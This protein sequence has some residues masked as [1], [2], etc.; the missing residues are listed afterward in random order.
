MKNG[1]IITIE[2]CHAI[3]KNFRAPAGRLTASGEQVY[4][5]DVTIVSGH[6][7]GTAYD[8]GPY[9][10]RKSDDKS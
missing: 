5:Y 3:V 6:L 7:K 8:G 1:D 4:L 2:D 9:S 10:W